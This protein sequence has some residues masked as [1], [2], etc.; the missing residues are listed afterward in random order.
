MIGHEPP[1]AHLIYVNARKVGLTAGIYAMVGNFRGILTGNYRRIVINAD[2]SFVVTTRL[3]FQ[4]TRL[5]VGQDLRLGSVG[6]ANRRGVISG[7]ET[8]NSGDVAGHQ[9]LIPLDFQALDTFDGG[10]ATRH[11]ARPATLSDSHRR[12]GDCYQCDN[13]GSSHGSSFC[14]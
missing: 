4:R 13:N 11:L 10:I 7:I 14:K 8:V 12:G 3:E 1:V 5:Q 2:V 9:S 6:A